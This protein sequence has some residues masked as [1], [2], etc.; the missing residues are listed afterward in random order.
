MIKKKVFY[1]HIGYSHLIFVTVD[2]GPLFFL[3]TVLDL[4]V[5]ADRYEFP[6][7]MK[8]LE[9][10]LCSHMDM[11]NVL[12]LMSYADMYGASVLLQQCTQYVDGNASLVLQSQSL[13]LIPKERLKALLCRDTFFA[14]EVDIFE[15][16]MRWKE[17]NGMEV[18][19]IGDVL[20][21]V[22]LAELSTAELRGVVAPSG[23]YSEEIIEGALKQTQSPSSYIRQPRGK[24]GTYTL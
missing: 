2:H 20:Q 13:L 10:L 16:V 8:S 6:S 4:L 12:Q 15:A 5:L 21:C 7:L 14:S 23:M 3:Q 18:S 11:S 24:L 1:F 19:E 22:R 17:F 9:R